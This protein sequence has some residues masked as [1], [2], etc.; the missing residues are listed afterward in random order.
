MN[1]QGIAEDEMAKGIGQ[2]VRQGGNVAALTSEDVETGQI[3]AMVGGPDFT[4]PTYGQNNYARTP[5]PPGSSFKPYDYAALMENT[6]NVGA[7]TV[8]YDTQEQGF[9]I[10]KAS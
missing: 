9:K 3:V 2:V 4:N 1:L 5:L 7:G 10:I 6:N 8:L